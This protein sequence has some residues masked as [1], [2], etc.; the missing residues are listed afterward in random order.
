[1]INSFEYT[2]K[3]LVKARGTLLTRVLSI[4]IGLIIGILVFAYL[5]FKFSY[6]K[7]YTDSDRIYQLR[8][9]YNNEGA[10]SSIALTSAAIAPELVSAMPQIETSTRLAQPFYYDMSYEEEVFAVHFSVVDTSF[11]DIF[12]VDIIQGNPK[13]IFLSESDVM[14]SESLAKTA[15]GDK[16][17]INKAFEHQGM[18]MVV[19]GLFKDPPMN[20]H[21]FSFNMLLPIKMLELSGWDLGWEGSNFYTYI[22]LQKNASIQDVSSSIN[23]LMDLHDTG[24][25]DDEASVNYFF[26]PLEKAALDYGGEKKILILLLALGILAIMIACLNY[27]L[28]SISTIDRRGKNMAMLRCSGA[29]RFDIF[30]LFMSETAIIVAIS[31]VISLFLIWCLNSQISSI[32]S[33]QLNDLFSIQ[34][35]WI[36]VVVLLG[37]FLLAGL[38]PSYL[39]ASIPINVAFKGIMKD[40]SLWKHFLLCIQLAGISFVL[41]L[42]LV[43]SVQFDKMQNSDMGYEHEDLVSIMPFGNL[44]ML[45]TYKNQLNELP[46]VENVGISFSMPIYSYST[47]DCYDESSKEYLFVSQRDE[48]DEDYIPTMG[49]SIVE[50]DNFDKSSSVNSVI[51]NEE[52]VRRRGWN[53]N[54]IG[55]YVVESNTSDAQLY[56]II[57]VVKNFRNNSKDDIQPLIFH[58]IKEIVPDETEDRFTGGMNVMIKLTETTPEN[59]AVLSETIKD[60]WSTNMNRIDVYDDTFMK[61]LEADKSF[62]KIVLI[63]SILTL[64]ITVIGLIGYLNEDIQKRKKEIAIRKVNGASISEITQLL[65]LRIFKIAGV[66]SVCG[67]VA[68]FF[69]NERWLSQFSNRV[70]NSLIFYLAGVVFVLL[71]AYGLNVY[72]AFK[73][74]C[75]NP[76]DVLR[77]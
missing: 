31:L 60:Y 61:Q 39:F 29:N 38:M 24:T 59:L 40:N 15:F 58:H 11:F 18:Q 4:T 67:V 48:I 72:K 64:L 73:A 20:T 53:D 17:P 33:Y 27:M 35:I 10:S 44:Q 21:L 52:Y 54:V 28:L 42:L 75:M 25:K 19:K 2:Y 16:D 13:E 8:S 71:F 22:K 66:S 47:I 69:V 3:Y 41:S 68:A 51:V 1:M 14:I 7:C 76:V 37:I 56:T 34:T 77:G 62:R 50:G 57:G 23:P 30:K 49:M 74:S 45:Q 55:K 70:D 65:A 26:V 12:D 9:H 46:I 36:P 63:V 5:G 6:D 43:I 32:I